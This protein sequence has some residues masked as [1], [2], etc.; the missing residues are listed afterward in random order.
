MLKG[1][2]ARETVALG[3][4]RMITRHRVKS[5]GED[6]TRL[7]DLVEEMGDRAAGQIDQAVRALADRDSSL[8]SAVIE[9]DGRIDQMRT[10]VH[11][12]AVRLLA[13]RQPMA[14]DLR[15]IVSALLI[16]RDL[17]RIGDY[18]ADI[19]QR[20]VAVNERQAVEPAAELPQLGRLVQGMTREVLAALAG[21]DPAKARAA[22]GRDREIDDLY[23]EVFRDVLR[24]MIFMMED[25]RDIAACTHLLF[26]G[27]NLEYIRDL[28]ADIAGAIL[29]HV[30]GDVLGSNRSGAGA[31]RSG[32][33]PDAT[34]GVSENEDQRP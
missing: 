2:P 33:E 27:K 26:I 32:T 13:L 20:T 15:H 6:L 7:S 4:T 28:A 1:P 11:E 12:Y 16:S 22:R 18:A 34:D 31:P 5:F 23:A 24:Y 9:G 25:P 30:E 14:V 8:A 10:D 21:K 17:E 3:M 19:A 29:Y